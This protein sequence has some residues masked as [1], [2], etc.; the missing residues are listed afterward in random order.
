MARTGSRIEGVSQ[1]LNDLLG[2]PP[3]TSLELVPPGPIDTILLLLDDYVEAALRLNPEVLEARATLRV[4]E[5]GVSAARAESLPDLG[6]GVTHLY[7]SSFDF[8]PRNSLGLG[9][10]FSWTPMD[11]GRRRSVAGERRAQLDQARAQLD[12]VEA[13]VR[14]EVEDAWR[15]LRY[16]TLL[17]ELAREAQQLRQEVSRLQESQRAAGLGLAADARLAEAETASGRVDLLQAEIAHRLAL[18]ELHRAT[19]ELVRR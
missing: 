4:A 16:A 10:Q 2:Y 14:R 19:G 6:I 5:H 1:E 13:R 15:S 11:G 7:Q 18:A 12:L 8:L 9:L 3:G 17:V